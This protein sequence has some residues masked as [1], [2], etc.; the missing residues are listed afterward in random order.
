MRTPSLDD[1]PPRSDSGVWPSKQAFAVATTTPAGA[2]PPLLNK[3]LHRRC[4]HP[5]AGSYGPRDTLR[6]REYNAKGKLQCELRLAAFAC[7]KRVGPLPTSRERGLSDQLAEALRPAVCLDKYPKSLVDVYV[8]VVQDDGSCM[9]LGRGEA[10][11]G[12]AGL[13][14]RP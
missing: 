12:H 3:P 13:R 10:G 5:C 11:A 1:P 2:P 8:T 6:T 7:Q 9:L 4:L 14:C